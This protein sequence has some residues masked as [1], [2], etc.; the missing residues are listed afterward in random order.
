MFQGHLECYQ[1]PPLG[2]RPSTKNGGRPW[3][4]DCS[5]LLSY[6]ILSCRR[7]CMNRNPLNQHLVHDFTVH[8][9]VRDRTTWILEV[10]WDNL[11]SLPFGLSQSHGR[12]S[13]LVCEV[14]LTTEKFQAWVGKMAWP[15][16]LLGELCGHQV[17]W[18]TSN[19]RTRNLAFGRIPTRGILS[20]SFLDDV[21]HLC[22][23]YQLF[24][25]I[26]LPRAN[27][28]TNRCTSLLFYLGSYGCHM[29]AKYLDFSVSGAPTLGWKSVS[30]SWAFP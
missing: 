6:S 13:W 24:P 30:G 21:F 16:C 7:T 3:H 11:Y 9:R 20:Y 28:L 4:F 27:F 12:G 1:K 5:Q 19:P 8:L 22:P 29:D 25:Q 18:T 23:P 17:S 10:Y 2:G 14:T 15:P 26:T